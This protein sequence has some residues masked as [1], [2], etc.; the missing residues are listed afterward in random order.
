[1][2]NKIIVFLVIFLVFASFSLSSAATN[3]NSSRS[4]IYKITP[5]GKTECVKKGGVVI[6]KKGKNGKSQYYC[7]PKKDVG[8]KEE[9]VK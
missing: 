1:M 6:E 5:D 9:G 2:K 7:Q 4:N 3:L 8:I